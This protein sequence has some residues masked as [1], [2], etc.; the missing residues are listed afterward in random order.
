MDHKKQSY[1]SKY[2]IDEKQRAHFPFH[3][4]THLYTYLECVKFGLLLPSK[5][6]RSILVFTI[7]CLAMT[8]L[9]SF[10]QNIR[11]DIKFVYSARKPSNLQHPVKNGAQRCIKQ[12]IAKNTFE[13]YILN[14]C[15]KVIF[16]SVVEVDLFSKRESC[17]VYGL[18]A[19]SIKH[20]NV[21]SAYGKKYDSDYYYRPNSLSAYYNSENALLRCKLTGHEVNGEGIGSFVYFS[22]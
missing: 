10:S 18:Q 7:F 12:K 4:S 9:N 1:D 11:D 3:V 21:E 14:R 16:L 17:A 20:N 13:K 15:D 19:S 2:P 22:K 8:S 6:A 5:Y